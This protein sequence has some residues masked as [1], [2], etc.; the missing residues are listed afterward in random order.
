MSRTAVVASFVAAAVAVVVAFLRSS[1]PAARVGAG[2]AGN[3]PTA[4]V[5]PGLAQGQPGL[6]RPAPEAGT[7]KTAVPG[8]TGVVRDATNGRGVAGAKVAAFAFAGRFSAAAD[9]DAEGRFAIS[10]TA[11][12]AEAFRVT[13]E[14]SGYARAVVER[15]VPDGAPPSIDL[16]KGGF[17]VA[18]LA[19]GPT[20]TT[21]PTV[22]VTAFRRRFDDDGVDAS[23]RDALSLL[24]AEQAR[25]ASASAGIDG[26]FRL[27]PLRAGTY[28]LLL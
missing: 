15:A 28:V 13:V 4:P 18:A 2:D 25:E 10:S 23:L 6:E 12:R 17:L 5:A 16:V 22:E 11:G 27:G 19:W 14:R 26:R 8:L 21:R 9:T 24:P 20:E 7:P 3:D 1:S